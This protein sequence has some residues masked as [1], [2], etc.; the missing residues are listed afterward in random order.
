MKIVLGGSSIKLYS[1]IT[2]VKKSVLLF[3]VLVCVHFGAWSFTFE[4][5][6]WHNFAGK[7]KGKMVYLALFQTNDGVVKGS[8]SDCDGNSKVIL[9]GKLTGKQIKLN[10]YLKGKIIEVFDLKNISDSTDKLQGT[11]VSNGKERFNVSFRFESTGSGNLEH[12][13]ADFYGVDDDVEQFM[14]GIKTAVK[15]GNKTWLAKNVHYPIVVNIGSNKKQTIKNQTQF[16]QQ[17]NKIFNPVY[18]KKILESCTC[19]LF[20]NYNGVMLGDGEIWINQ[21]PGST[22]QSYD[23][24]IITINNF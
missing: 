24:V 13:Y 16:L 23:F 1:H 4:A 5:N 18:K 19:N 10:G 7:L 6:Q 21:K 2:Q 14:A 9:S 17:Y 12:K 20:A 22:E 8:Y 11:F 3:L 15:E